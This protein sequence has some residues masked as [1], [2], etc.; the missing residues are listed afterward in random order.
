MPQTTINV[1]MDEDVKRGLEKFCFDVGLNVSVAVNMFAKTVVR[2]Q[3]LPFEVALPKYN[4]KTLTAMQ[5]AVDIASGKIQA[6]GYQSLVELNA[7]LDAEYDAE[8][9]SLC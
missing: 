4:E 3:R 9:G 7:E 1:R 2:E 8:Y 6:K 5:E